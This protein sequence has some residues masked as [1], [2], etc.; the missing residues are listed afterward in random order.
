MRDARSARLAGR[1][2]RTGTLTGPAPGAPAGDATQMV[3]P[4]AP[5]GTAA[6]GLTTRRAG[7][8]PLGWVTPR[9]SGRPLPAPLRIG[10]WV[11][12]FVLG[13]AVSAFIL[14]KIGILSVNAVIDLY[15]G[16][17]L[18]RFGILIV[19][20]PLWAVLSALIAHFSIEGLTKRRDA[21][22]SSTSPS[23][24]SSPPL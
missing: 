21:R 5:D 23:A 8:A 11:A 22:A 1:R 9:R 6:A 3:P 24:T 7:T 15:A 19:L 18:G 17:G 14:R 2:S 16:T 12:A 10:V 4:V 20:L 13:L